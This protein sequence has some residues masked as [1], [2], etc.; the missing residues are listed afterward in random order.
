[1]DVDNVYF[2]QV[3]YRVES[4]FFHSFSFFT[5]T[6]F[7]TPQNVKTNID[8]DIPRSFKNSQIAKMYVCLC[9]IHIDTIQPYL[10]NFVVYIF[11]LKIIGEMISTTTKSDKV[12]D[13]II[14][15]MSTIITGRIP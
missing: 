2:L 12:S 9:A 6:F 11:Q 7:F 15:P 4:G 3:G 14:F 5:L 10:N 8:N 13:V 1:M